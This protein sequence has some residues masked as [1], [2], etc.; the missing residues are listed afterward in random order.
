MSDMRFIIIGI[1]LIFFGFLVL[2]VFGHGY[3]TGL[4]ETNQF[5]SCHKYFEN[6]DPEE[7]DCSTMIFDQSLFFGVVLVLI[8]GGI[9]S[10]IKGVKGDWDNKINPEDKEDQSKNKNSDKE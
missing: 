2:G 8:V 1:S 4:I 7:V 3:Q 6:K 9:I 5:D 10:L